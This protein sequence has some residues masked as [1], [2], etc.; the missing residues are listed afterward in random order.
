MKISTIRFS[1]LH[2]EAHY[3]FL[4]LVKK[5]F[6]AYPSVANIVSSL[7]TPFYTLPLR[8]KASW[9]TQSGSVVSRV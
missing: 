9:S 3:Q 2:N 4:L 5:L 7:L 1:Y 6:E 8:S